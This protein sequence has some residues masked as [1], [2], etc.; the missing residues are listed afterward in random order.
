MNL[1]RQ[2]DAR[3]TVARLDRI[4]EVDRAQEASRYARPRSRVP[5]WQRVSP[6]LAVCGLMVLLCLAVVVAWAGRWWGF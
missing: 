4:L 2:I 5:V 1:S 3:R 6:E